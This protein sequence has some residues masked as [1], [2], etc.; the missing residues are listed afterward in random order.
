MPSYC[1]V[2][3]PFIQVCKQQLPGLCFSGEFQGSEGFEGS[4]KKEH[5]T[6]PLH[7]VVHYKV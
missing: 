5:P 3:L 2:A 6:V 1:L 7:V 4:Y